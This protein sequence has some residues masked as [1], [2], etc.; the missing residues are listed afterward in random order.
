MKI[1][2]VFL[3]L[4]FA[5]SF[6]CF[7]QGISNN[8]LQG[9]FQGLGESK[10]DFFSGS[11]VISQYNV[12][13]DFNHT[14]ANITDTAGN[15]LFYTNGYYIA[16]ANNDTMFN[17]SGLTPGA[18]ANDF[19]DGFLIPQGALII[20]KPGSNSIYYLFHSV[21]DNY[22]SPGGNFALKLCL[23]TIDMSLNSGLGGVISKNVPLINDSLNLGKI[24][25]TRA[26][27]GLSW[28]VFTHK[29][30]TNTFYKLLITPGGILGPY[31]QSIGSIREWDVGQMKFSPDGKRLA[32]YH[33]R[34]TGLDIFDFDRCS[35]I[36]SNAINDSVPAIEFGPV[37]CEFSPNS[38]VLY[39]TEITK[40]YQYNLL[41]AN[42]IGSRQVVATYDGFEQPGLPGFGTYLCQPQLAPDGKIY[43][44]TGNSTTYFGTIENPDS[45][46][47]GCNVAQHSV[48]L[49]TYYFNTLPNHPNY[50]LGCDTT[51]GCPCS[52]TSNTNDLSLKENRIKIFPN[53]TTGKFTLQF[54]VQSTSGRAQVYDINGKQVLSEYIAPWSQYKHLDITNLPKSIYLCKLIWGSMETGIKVIK[55]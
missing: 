21:D 9:Y 33:Y 1:L 42:V 48:L 37:G 40:I 55:E 54:N 10:M 49:P 12:P 51:L 36:L 4:F 6:N 32:Y 11:P 47:I 20:P 28:W 16:N 30:N 7:G 26:A 17:G 2:K 27:N 53:P 35:G 43:I 23:T 52:I 34:F 18:Y 8:W 3:F 15:L 24:T 19:Y 41:A 31:T 50:F 13:M 45:V 5:A 29:L 44:T 22:P 46:G 14:H 25:A 39:V 38:N